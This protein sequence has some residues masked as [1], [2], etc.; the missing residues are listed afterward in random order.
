MLFPTKVLEFTPRD[1]EHIKRLNDPV[2]TGLFHLETWLPFSG[3]SK[4]ERGN[5]NV[6]PASERK[7]PFRDMINTVENSPSTFHRK[8]RGI[9]Y[10]CDR[11]EFDNKSRLL[12]VTIPDID[13][14]EYED[15]ENGEPKF[16]IADGGHTFEVIQQTVARI[17]ELREREGWTEPFVR[18]H[19]LA[20]QGFES[21]ELEQ[22]VEALNTSSQVQQFTLDEYQNKFD[23][24]KEALQNGGFDPSVVAFRENEDKEW[25]VRDIVQRLACFLKERWKTTQPASMYRSKGK[26]LDLYT[27]EATHPEFR[28]LYDVA[29]DIVTLPEY[30][31]SEFSKDTGKG[32]KFGKIRAVKTLKKPWT[33]AGTQYTTDHE[34]DLAASLPIAAAFRELLELK[35]DRYYWKVDYKD[36]FKVAADELYKV[37]LN[38]V[39]TAKAVN[40]LGADTEYWTQCSNIVLRAMY[41]VLNRPSS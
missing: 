28:K 30:I 17:N 6:R 7:K 40:S 20:G 14:K 9:I 31:Q 18:V 41:E 39:R 1:N 8:N 21:G 15:L 23:E 10:L 38:K 25:D 36:V 5:A 12:R 4:L 2:D 16:G 11:F 13:P 37:L 32:R 22:L 29:S 34:M 35:G 3:A 19:F 24:L 27:N 26:A 33:P